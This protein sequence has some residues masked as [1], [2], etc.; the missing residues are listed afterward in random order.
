MGSHFAQ[1]APQTPAVPDPP[2]S[3]SIDRWRRHRDNVMDRSVS[4]QLPAGG[5]Y[6]FPG[7][8]AEPLF[9]PRDSVVASHQRRPNRDLRADFD[10]AERRTNRQ[11]PSHKAANVIYGTQTSADEPGSGALNPASSPFQ[12]A[13]RLRISSKGRQKLAKE[14]TSSDSWTGDDEFLAPASARRRYREQRLAKKLADAAALLDAQEPPTK[15]A[16]PK[17]SPLKNSPRPR[18]AQDR[19]IPIRSPGASRFQS[20]VSEPEPEPADVVIGQPPQMQPDIVRPVAGPAEQI[21]T[22]LESGASDGDEEDNIS[23]S[24]CD[25]SAH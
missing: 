20:A 2:A 9:S 10:H 7:N 25:K 13:Q 16:S 8:A 22:P 19:S 3:R 6:P 21:D 11:S 23:D 15:D 18:L 5:G 24:Q 1:S 14:D 4:L 12:T 17:D